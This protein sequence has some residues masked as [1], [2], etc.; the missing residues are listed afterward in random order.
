MNSIEQEM[1]QIEVSKSVPTGRY[2]VMWG[3]LCV[4]S[5]PDKRGADVLMWS[6]RRELE[7]VLKRFSVRGN[8]WRDVFLS[9]L[10]GATRTP[11]D[12][13]CQPKDVCTYAQ[14]LADEAVQQ[15]LGRE[16]PEG[17]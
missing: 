2:E 3:N 12:A 4:A 17:K 7:S 1:E 5:A 15:L 6:L 16:L 11:E 8:L 10:S 13:P 14:N 9:V